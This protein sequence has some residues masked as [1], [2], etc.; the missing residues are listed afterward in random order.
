LIAGNGIFPLEVARAARALGLSLIAVAHRDESPPELEQICHRVTWIKVGELQRIIDTF[1]HAGVTRSAMAGGISRARLPDAFAPDGRALAMLARIGRFSDDAVLRGVAAELE[2]E[3][4]AV[5]D[6]VPMLKDALVP[7]G[8]LVGPSP[9]PAQLADM[10]LA[11]EVLGAIGRFDVGQ[12]VAV[13]DGV[14]YA[15]EAVEGTDAA[16]RRAFAAG[17]RGL[18]IAKA[19]KSSQD[20][21]FDRPTIGPTTFDLLA[22]IGAAVLG[23][24]AGQAMIVQRDEALAR[25]RGLNISV[26]GYD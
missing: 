20:L 26:Y 25:A 3:G 24:Q 17:G 5:I 19:A 21:R 13:R 15:I 6:P 2:A 11:F 4:I 8:L 23:V 12:T 10:R 16:L 22:E 1:K 14:V 18:V 7:P 9:S